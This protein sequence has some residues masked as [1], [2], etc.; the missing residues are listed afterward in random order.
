MRF[1]NFVFLIVP[2]PGLKP[3]NIFVFTEIFT[4]IVFLKSRFQV[5]ISGN[6]EISNFHYPNFFQYPSNNSWKLKISGYRYL[7]INNFLV[8]IP[9]NSL[10]N[11]FHQHWNCVH[12]RKKFM[13]GKGFFIKRL[14]GGHVILHEETIW[15]AWDPSW[16][17]YMAGMGF[18]LTPMV[19]V[20]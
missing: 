2:G 6:W 20:R 12:M 1:S 16:R 15:W 11:N 18:F 9:G 3:Y 13:V 17:D 5:R 14:H 4:K 7:E 19:P 8:R 10:K